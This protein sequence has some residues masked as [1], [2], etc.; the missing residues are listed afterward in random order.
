[1]TPKPCEV[2]HPSLNPWPFMKWGMNIV[3]KLPLGPRQKVFMLALTD[4]F[5]KWIEADSF[6]QVRDKEVISFHIYEQHLQVWC[7]ISYMR[8][9]VVVYHQ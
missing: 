7:S 6:R 4:Y 9:W 1:M 3:G 2:M 5:S 8:Q